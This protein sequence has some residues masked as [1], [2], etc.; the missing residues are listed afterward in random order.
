MDLEVNSGRTG[1]SS[2][3]KYLLSKIKE[4]DEQISLIERKIKNLEGESEPVFYY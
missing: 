3:I 4:R 1:N 2:H